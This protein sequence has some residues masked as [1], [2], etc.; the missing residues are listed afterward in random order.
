MYELAIDR[1][2]WIAAMTCGQNARAYR[3][4]GNNQEADESERIQAEFLA[5]AAALRQISGGSRVVRAG[6]TPG[7][8]CKH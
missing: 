1:L 4:A 5:A 8:P 3:M 2:E 7:N 6:G